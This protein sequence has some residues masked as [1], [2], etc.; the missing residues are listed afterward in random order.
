MVDFF[1]AN[2]RATNKDAAK[3]LNCT[4]Q[5]IS[6]LRNNGLYKDK[7]AQRLAKVRESYDR[8]ITKNLGKL[9]TVSLETLNKRV[10]EHGA[11]MPTKDLIDSA[12]LAIKGLGYG[13]PKQQSNGTS[14]T[15]AVSQSV[16]DEAQGKLTK[17]VQD[18][19]EP[20]DK[21]D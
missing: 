8:E 3:Y 18:V 1:I 5:H 6:N 19:Y 12:E 15:I 21:P 17:N 14:V 20:T 11:E 2:P 7:W 13:N 10:V 9:G 4:P 16:L